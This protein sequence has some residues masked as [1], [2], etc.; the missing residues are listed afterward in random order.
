[1]ADA[2][3]LPKWKDLLRKVHSQC[4]DSTIAIVNGVSMCLRVYDKVNENSY[5]LSSTPTSVSYNS[6]S[7]DAFVSRLFDL[8]LSH[9]I[10]AEQS[11]V[12]PDYTMARLVFHVIPLTDYT[13]T[14]IVPELIEGLKTAIL[15]FPPLGM[16]D[17]P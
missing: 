13:E 12:D 6:L 3:K 2:M 15:E 7:V 11:I 17:E 14:N 8:S 10:V 4:N 5:S 1:M 9:G 16:G